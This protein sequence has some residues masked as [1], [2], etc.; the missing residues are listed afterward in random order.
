MDKRQIKK[1]TGRRTPWINHEHNQSAW[2]MAVT[3][4]PQNVC[5]LRISE[6]RSQL[7]RSSI[8]SGMTE[9]KIYCKCAGILSTGS[10]SLIMCHSPRLQYDAVIW[11]GA[12][13]KKKNS[14]YC[15]VGWTVVKF[16]NNSKRGQIRVQMRQRLTDGA[17]MREAGGTVRWVAKVPE[18]T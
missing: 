3:P 15:I 6:P 10:D 13:K 17:C 2:H 12:K 9:L 16:Q 4:W 8:L 14:F 1:T 11:E 7:V 18:L 5:S